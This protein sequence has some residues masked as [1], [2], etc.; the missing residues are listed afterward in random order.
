MN[1]S[2]IKVR[3]V[4]DPHF[5]PVQNPLVALLLRFRLDRCHVAAASRLRDTVR[6]AQRGLRTTAEVLLFLSLA[7]GDNDWH[8]S[9]II[10]GD[11]SATK[12]III[13]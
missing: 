8:L 2:S 11:G 5:L 3:T 9:E 4:C 7:T 1:K 10:C 6:N 13:K 12:S